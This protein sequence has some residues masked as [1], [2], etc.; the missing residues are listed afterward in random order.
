MFKRKKIK[1]SINTK[2]DIASHIK[3]L[4]RLAPKVPEYTC[5]DIDFIVERLE[6]SYNT[7]KYIPRVTLKVLLRKLERL[8]IQNDSLRE[9]GIYWYRKFKD[10]IG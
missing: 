3:R 5:P 1:N 2:A 10:Y 8:R 7:K 6:K 4:K 9:Q